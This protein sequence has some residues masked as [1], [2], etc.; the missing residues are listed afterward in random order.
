MDS[1]TPVT[2]PL[3]VVDE[4]VENVSAST[5]HFLRRHPAYFTVPL[6]VTVICEALLIWN[7]V[8]S[9]G[10]YV[11]P[12]VFPFV[13]YNIAHGKVE[14]EFMQQFAAANGFSYA[15]RGTLDGLDGSLFQIGHSKSVENVV[16]GQ[17]QSDP[18]SLFT[19]VYVTGYGR[20]QQRHCYTVFEL[21]FDIVLPDMLL[22]NA[23]HAFGEALFVHFQG[24][25]LIK[26]EGDFNKYF[27]LSVPKGYE[28][29]ALEIFT[30]DIMQELMEKAKAFSVE[31]VNGH[32]FIYDNGIVGTKQGLYDLYG[33]AQYFIE[34][35]GPV[36]G[37]MKPSEAAM[38][39]M[40]AQKSQ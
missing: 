17:F 6:A 15:L 22:E 11:L 4:D 29:E 40:A 10:L 21:Q 36:L 30:P 5:G 13:G 35:L 38:A 37:R 14:R 2:S 31:I 18:V 26:L 24:K 9:I 23:N 28:V 39:A 34:K 1:E 3:P 33:L 16:S 12:V 7:H 25:E 8:I 32:L 19:Y 20:N 27:S